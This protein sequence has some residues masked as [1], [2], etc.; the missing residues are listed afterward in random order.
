MTNTRIKLCCGHRV[1]REARVQS[2]SD[3][4]WCP[5]CKRELFTG[6]PEHLERHADLAARLKSAVVTYLDDCIETGVQPR[7]AAIVNACES[8]ITGNA[9]S[10]GHRSGAAIDAD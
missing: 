5:I 10:Q 3:V 4:M 7:L 6:W 9:F 8:L 1:E 2:D